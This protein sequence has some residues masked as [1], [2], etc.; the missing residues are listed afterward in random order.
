MK[1]IF[2]MILAACST[3]GRKDCSAELTKIVRADQDAR[4]NFM[5][6]SQKDLLQMRED[7]IHRREMVRVL[8]DQNCFE[9]KQDYS[10]AA[11]VFQHGDK[12]ED[13]FQSF[14]WSKK[15][16]DKSLMA[17]SLDRYLVSKGMKQLFGSQANKGHDSKCW[18]L[19]QTEMNF[20][21]T[22]RKVFTG[23]TLADQINWMK[24]MN[25]GSECPRV[26]C[27]RELSP[28]LTEEHNLQD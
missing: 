24:S 18:C 20:S 19:E 3:T 15:A 5:N 16:G 10:N 14:Q 17:L 2:L 25:Q 8:A 26:Y 7:D 9:S 21:D 6:L 11:L 22:K 13:F 1:I 23:K 4:G 28:S 12:P 27:S